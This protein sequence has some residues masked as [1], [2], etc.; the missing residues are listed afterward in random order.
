MAAAA[1]GASQIIGP[2]GTL[3]NTDNSVTIDPI[4]AQDLLNV[5]ITPGGMSVKKREGYGQAFSLPITTS[6]VHGVYRFYEAGGNDVSLFFNDI[7]MSASISGGSDDIIMSSGTYGAVYYCVDSQGSAYCANNNN[8]AIIKTEGT[9]FSRL[10]TPSTG[11]TL[12]VM[13]TRL[14]MAGFTDAPN[15]IDFSAEADFTDWTT[16]AECTDSINYTI[17]SPGTKIVHLVFAFDQILWFKEES[18]GFV[19][20]GPCHGDWTIG[21]ISPT[22][23][24]RDNASILID[25][26]LLFFRGQDGHY[27]M[28]DGANLTKISREIDRTIELSR[29]LRQAYWNQTTT[30]DWGDGTYNDNKVYVDTQTYSGNL[31]FTFPDYFINFRDG[32]NNT[33]NVWTEYATGATGDADAVGGSL[34]LTLGGSSLERVYVRTTEKLEDFD[35][36]TTVHFTISDFG[37]NPIFLDRFYVVLSSMATTS[38]FPGSLNNNIEFVFS[39]TEPRKI[40]LLE[41]SSDD[42]ATTKLYFSNSIESAFPG[43]IDITIS[44]T[45]VSVKLNDVSTSSVHA[46]PNNE[47]YVY[48]GFQKGSAGSGLVYVDNFTIVPQTATYMSPI[49]NASGLTAWDNFSATKLETA[50]GEHSFSIR[51]ST[52]SFTVNSATPTWTVIA[53]GGKPSISTGTY[54]QIKDHFNRGSVVG[55][56]AL[57]DFTVNWFEGSASEVYAQHHEDALWWTVASGGGVTMNNQVQRFDLINQGWTIYDI[58]ANGLMVRNQDLYFG[59]VSSGYI[60]KFGGVND[61][62]GTAIEAYWK[63]KDFV[64]GNPFVEKEIDRV[65]VAAASVGGSSVTVTY[66]L[67]GSTS[68]AYSA[69]L[70]DSESTFI[71]NNRR[72]PV[73]E[74]GSIFNIKIGNDAV[75]NPF[76]IFAIQYG[77]KPKV[78]RETE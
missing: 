50:T 39:S 8:D 7:Y 17:V 9:T 58:A 66:T 5:E 74:V 73:G 6:G 44:T 62:N 61:D 24:T 60:Y 64:M 63:S 71:K 36:G 28:Y 16:S 15:R 33:K 43:V 37:S 31:D 1:F 41:G 76:E 59:D 32:N 14:A 55:D 52:G 11:T 29:P 77:V 13:P 4:K 30:L 27:Y 34:S 10:T 75:D 26:N 54:L 40:F 23:G 68:S 35:Q 53:S 25:N 22:I 51:A 19:S 72:L 78:W 46:W 49:F 12:A 69:E 42:G 45:N 67:D 18:F 21:T 70:F 56:I 20:E 38:N 57:Y 48:L 47:V 3:N 2:F 65:S